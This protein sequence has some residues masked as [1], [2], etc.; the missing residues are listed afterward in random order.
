MRHVEKRQE[1][2]VKLE[3]T[4]VFVRKY[5]IL[6]KYIDLTEIMYGH[7]SAHNQATDPPGPN[8]LAGVGLAGTAPA[9]GK[10]G[11]TL[12]PEAV[13]DGASTRTS[14]PIT[15]CIASHG[16]ACSRHRRPMAFSSPAESRAGTWQNGQY[17]MRM[18][19][20]PTPFP[21]NP[22]CPSPQNL[23]RRPSQPLSGRFAAQGGLSWSISQEALHGR[24][25]P[26]PQCLQL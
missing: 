1:I 24:L 5:T 8:K 9:Y 23:A 10:G 20:A 11:G 13:L 2:A 22:T 16:A 25:G 17:G 7:T 4:G 15:A 6:R 14:T 26:C 21:R 12:I 3:F 18:N 19:A